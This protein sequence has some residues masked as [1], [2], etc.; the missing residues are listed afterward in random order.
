MKEETI[1][2]FKEHLT[3]VN[4]EAFWEKCQK[5]FPYRPQTEKV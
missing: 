3:E 1:N 2:F 4:G 5:E